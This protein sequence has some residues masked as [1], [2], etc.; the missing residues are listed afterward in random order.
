MKI[1]L[2]GGAGYIGSH[3]CL[4]LLLAGHDVVV[5]D[6]LSNSDAEAIRRV[7]QLSG[8]DVDLIVMDLCD[9]AS[10]EALFSKHAFEAVIHF[11]G[12]K[13]VGESVKEPMRYYT[14]NIDSTLVL[15]AAMARH[16][17]KTLVF[18]SSATVYGM[19]EKMPVTE[20]AP[21][22][23][24]N[25]Y[26]R[27]KLMIEQ[28]LADLCASDASW[29]VLALRY[30]NPAGAHDSG[31]IGEDPQGTPNNLFP[32]VSQV[33][34]GR[35]AALR[36]WGKDYPTPDGTGVR[37]YIHVT[38]LARGH[39]SAVVAATALGG[40]SAINLGTGRGYSV[41]EVVSA[42]SRACGRTLPHE[43]YP[44]REGDVAS[45]WADPSLALNL[46][47]WKAERDLAQMCEDA[48]RWQSSNPIGYRK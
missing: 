48:W 15:L 3:T 42:F 43:F 35:H 28:I 47:G 10:T 39:V 14:N 34:A 32:Y 8:Q 5:A 31:M 17:V 40:F 7:R 29:N 1:L 36:I 19:P 6:N 11:A 41:L 46:L 18:S 44:R 16:Q 25:P 45:C 26:G 13:A 38:D 2:T 20:S 22:S 27:T 4:E 24:M 21:L 23:A 9:S 33:A 12:L 37:D 30:F